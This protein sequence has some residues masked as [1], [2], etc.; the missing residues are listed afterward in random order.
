[1]K[2]EEKGLSIRDI[3][4]LSGVS[5]ATVS[6]VINRNGR[7]SK[8]TEKRVLDIME[9]Y[10]YVPNMTARRLRTKEQN[11]IAIIIPDITNEFFARI[12][13]LLQELLLQKGYLALLCNTAEN[14]DVQR[15]YLEM[16]GIVN[17]A[18]I[19]FVSGDAETSHLCGLMELPTIYIDRAPQG[20]SLENALVV[21]S[22]NY[23]GA[24]MAVREMAEKGCR[25]IA[26]L[27][28]AQVI[29]THSFRQSGYLDEL[30]RL[31][32]KADPQ[33][34][35]QVNQVSFEDA[36]KRVNQLIAQKIEFDGIFCATDYLAVGAMEA[37]KENG[38]RV[39]EQVKV[40]GFDDLSIARLAAQPITT[41]HQDIEAISQTAAEEMV[42]IIQGK[43]N[44]TRRFQIGVS[45]IRRK[46][47]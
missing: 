18:G 25:R 2:K 22:D 28:S 39:P 30:S 16:L 21:E 10:H 44:S 45:L 33:L 15:Q 41:I 40:V 6:R 43:E 26:F 17:L 3:S 46:T 24:A 29:T 31:G 34:I 4:R 36:K 14:M 7:F 35:L 42:R 9:Q 23:G 32:M 37:L 47:T 1:M 20:A 27:R 8:D 5:I 38:I 12:S 11:F 13:Q 19:I